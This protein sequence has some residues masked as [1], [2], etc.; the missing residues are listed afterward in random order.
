MLNM[1]HTFTLITLA[2]LIPA[3]SLAAPKGVPKTTRVMATGQAVGVDLGAEDEAKMD[4]K[5][6]AVRQGCGEL[7]TATTLIRDY[8]TVEDRVLSKAAGYIVDNQ[9]Q[10]VCQAD[11]QNN[12]TTCAID[13]MVAWASL[14]NAL[15][16]IP[17]RQPR[18]AVAMLEEYNPADGLPPQFSTQWQAVIEKAFIDLGYRVV[19]QATVQQNLEKL[20]A[21]A[22]REGDSAQDADLMRRLDAE[23]VGFFQ[24][25]CPPCT[26]KHLPPPLDNIWTCDASLTGRAVQL[27]TATVLF[28]DTL[29]ADP[30]V[31]SSGPVPN[32]KEVKKFLTKVGGQAVR[33]IKTKIDDQEY[34]TRSVDCTFRCGD[35]IE[36]CVDEFRKIRGEI[37]R[38]RGVE[39]LTI[40]Q[41][42]PT[43]ILTEI[44]YAFPVD[45]LAQALVESDSETY[46]FATEQTA[47]E[48]LTI[49][50]SKR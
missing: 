19:D 36:S 21:A 23:I 32:S 17:W 12:I 6:N 3:I 5:R 31:K 43:M 13:A 28:A 45:R 16:G 26:P 18:I 24:F 14:D 47:A 25:T 27:D 41:G 2:T 9:S 48:T 11:P 42:L 29:T 15:K 30:T 34:N 1:R 37:R 44:A 49:R 22:N 20:V 4:A 40:R 7:I 46:V 35:G 39:D 33:A 8:E 38:I 50:V 10:I